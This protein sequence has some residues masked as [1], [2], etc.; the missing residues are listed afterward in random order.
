VLLP[1]PVLLEQPARLA[2]MAVSAIAAAMVV[3]R[4]TQTPEPIV[5]RFGR[6]SGQILSGRC[7][8]RVPKVS[9]AGK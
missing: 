6:L 1:P 4:I 2:L 3:R 8:A 5:Y 9:L 7:A